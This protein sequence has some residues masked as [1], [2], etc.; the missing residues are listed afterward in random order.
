MEPTKSRYMQ[1][2]LTE[3]EKVRFLRLCG[4]SRLEFDFREYLDGSLARLRSV[5][6]DG[7]RHGVLDPG[8]SG[9]DSLLV[10]YPDFPV[11]QPLRKLEMDLWQWL[12]PAPYCQLS[13]VFNPPAGVT[14]E[15]SSEQF[16]AKLAR[17]HRAFARLESHLVKSESTILSVRTPRENG[18]WLVQ[19]VRHRITHI[20][21]DGWLSEFSRAFSA[22]SL[23]A[24]SLRVP[25]GMHGQYSELFC[26]LNQPDPVER[27][28]EA[29]DHLVR[30]RVANI[31][32]PPQDGFATSY[33]LGL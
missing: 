31:G 6:T 30:D 10:R 16:Q 11:V 4:L 14:V 27:L 23:T 9:M 26:D 33:E 32:G 22:G 17:L 20:G 25:L 12:L 28:P 15:Y 13:L 7:T 18:C 21:T 24:E 19:S 2:P 29:I 3:G 1:T 8:P 5:R